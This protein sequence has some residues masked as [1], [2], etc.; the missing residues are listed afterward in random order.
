MLS[1]AS[2]NADF[3]MYV[4]RPLG[5]AETV[6]ARDFTRLGGGKAANRAFLAN[7]L[8]CPAWL[9]GRVGADEMASRRWRR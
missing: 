3:Q 4:D 2:V 5:S 6:P 1:L 9:L 7:K 8:G